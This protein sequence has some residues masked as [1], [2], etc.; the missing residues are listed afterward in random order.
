MSSMGFERCFATSA[1]LMSITVGALTQSLGCQ[2]SSQNAPASEP[3]P[4]ENASQILGDAAERSGEEPEGY[5]AGSCDE[6]MLKSV[7]AE[8]L[9]QSEG[10]DSAA[11]ALR[12]GC[13]AEQ[14]VQ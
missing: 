13:A 12:Q 7:A 4:A 2:T 6:V 11:E 10:S 1:L 5:G 3:S 14:G 8:M 9:V